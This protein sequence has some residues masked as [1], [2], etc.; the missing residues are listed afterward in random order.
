M[1]GT[2]ELIITSGTTLKL[3]EDYGLT[4]KS[5]DID[6]NRLYLELIKNG[7]VV[8]SGIIIANEV[9]DTFIYSKP[10]TSQAIKVHFKNAFRGRDRNFATIDSITQTS[11]IRPSRLLI[12]NT[13][14]STILSGTILELEEG[15][16]L[17]VRAIDID[18]N[19]TYVE[20][21]KDGDV[22]AS[23]LIVAANEVDDAY[24][25]SKPGASE[26]IKVH[27]RNA[28]RGANQNLVTID[29]TA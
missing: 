18:G 12:N 1:N 15:F 21:L 24:V 10:G 20:L 25:Y 17:A 11:E 28:F 3:A 26:A 6:G 9:D 7:R 19:K 23:K 16:S 13:H 14:E 8:E 2:H 5:V 22:V 29:D 4:I 27:F